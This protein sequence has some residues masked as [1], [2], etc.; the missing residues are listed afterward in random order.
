MLQAMNTGHEGS[1]TTVHANSPRDAIS[2]LETMVLMCNANMSPLVIGRQIASA[3]NVVVH[4]R[5]YS[6]GVRRVESI[7]ELTGLEGKVITMQEIISFVQTGVSSEG[8]CLGHYKLHA[9]KPKFLERA[10]A[11][12][13]FSL[14]N[15]TPTH[16]ALAK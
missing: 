16:T 8:K 3:L 15:G 4:I 14:S 6:D 5:R 2:R 9:V 10:K 12:G 7:S 1:L 11:F 13:L